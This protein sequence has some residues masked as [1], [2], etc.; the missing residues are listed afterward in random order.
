MSSS[1]LS[2]F[3]RDLDLSLLSACTILSPRS[4]ETSSGYL[5]L[6]LKSAL[7]PISEAIVLELSQRTP[8]S[9]YLSGIQID[10]GEG[11]EQAGIPKI[12]RSL[13]ILPDYLAATKQPKNVAK[14]DKY[15]GRSGPWVKYLTTRIIFELAWPDLVQRATRV[16]S[17]QRLGRST[18]RLEPQSSI[19]SETCCVVLESIRNGS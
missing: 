10:P 4:P 1:P 13:G 12:H 18:P 7:E 19:P 16:F 17:I 2:N 11:I 8:T 6:P 15:P 5:L 14:C 9:A 3:Y